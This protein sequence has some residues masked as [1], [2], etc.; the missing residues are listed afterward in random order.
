VQVTDAPSGVSTDPSSSIVE[1][2]GTS[3]TKSLSRCWQPVAEASLYVSAA[4]GAAQ[5]PASVALAL[6]VSLTET[7]A[8][9][10]PVFPY[11]HDQPAA[12]Q[13]HTAC[14]QPDGQA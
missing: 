3:Q 10:H 6:A 5:A 8:S 9:T 4:A 14:A 2:F 11:E 13:A 1:P 7:L 12:V